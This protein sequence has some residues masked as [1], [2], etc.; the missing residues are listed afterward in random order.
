[1]SEPTPTAND[2][3]DEN[4]TAVAA[5][6]AAEDVSPPKV[7]EEEKIDEL[8]EVRLPIEEEE[9]EEKRNGEE[10]PEDKDEDDDKGDESDSEGGAQIAR[11]RRKRR[12][13]ELDEDDY[14]LLE[15]NQVTGFKRKEK[16]KRLQKK[17][18]AAV[19]EDDDDDD[20]EKEDQQKKEQEQEQEEKDT[21]KDEVA[22]ADEE[23]G[24]E[25]EQQQ[26]QDDAEEEKRRAA[27][28]E[29][30]FVDSDDEDSE[31]EMADFIVRDEGEERETDEERARRKAYNRAQRERGGARYDQV[32]EAA[33][34][35]GDISDLQKL[36]ANRK[37]PGDEGYLGGESLPEDVLEEESQSEYE[38]DDE[39]VDDF[40]VDDE[41]GGERPPREKKMRKVRKFKKRTAGVTPTKSWAEFAF[42]PSVIKAQMLTATDDEIRNADWP[43]RLS[44]ENVQVP[45]LNTPRDFAEEATWIYDRVMGVGSIRGIPTEAGELLLRGKMDYESDEVM[46]MRLYQLQNEWGGQLPDTERQNVLI[47]IEWFLKMVRTQGYELEYLATN[48]RDDLHPLLRGKPEEARPP[49]VGDQV[50]IQRKTRSFDVLQAVYDWDIAYVKLQNRK[51]KAIETLNKELEAHSNDQ[52]SV[53]TLMRLQK[54]IASSKYDENVQDVESK[55]QLLLKDGAA[56]LD[57]NSTGGSRRPRRRTAYDMHVSRD[58]LELFKIS[59]PAPEKVAMALDTT[60][61]WGEA[62]GVYDV[63]DDAMTEILPDASPEELAKHYLDQGYEDEEDVIKAL[64]EVSATELANDPGIRQWV[65]FHYRQY[66]QSTTKPT[67]LGNEQIDTFHPLAAVKRTLN[68]P[69]C[70]F[71]DIEFSM[72]AEGVRKGLLEFDAFLPEQEVERLVQNLSNAYC[73]ENV[74]EKAEQWNTIRRKVVEDAIKK[75]LV[76]QI[77]REATAQL[78]LE[79]KRS[80]AIAAFNGAWRMLNKKSWTPQLIGVKEEDVHSTLKHLEVRIISAVPASDQETPTTLVS[81]D[82]SG[83]LVDFLELTSFG[84]SG[85]GGSYGTQQEEQRKVA[86][87]ISNHR[88]HLVAV[89]ASGKNA[90][91]LKEE[92]DRVTGGFLEKDGFVKSIPE[93]VS[94]IE[95]E[96]INDSVASLYETASAPVKEMG[97][98]QATI[99]HAVAL[100]RFARDPAAVV[101]NLLQPSGGSHEAATISLCPF[102]DAALSREERV[103][104]IERALRCCINQ[105]GVDVNAAMS[106]QWIARSLEHVAGL[107]PRKLVPFLTAIRKVDGGALDNREE[108]LTELHAVEE[109]VYENAASA[110]NIT[111]GNVLDGSRIHP[112]HYDKAIA[113][114]SNALDIQIDESG[115]GRERAL[116]RCFDPREWPKLSVLMLE[117]YANYLSTPEGG[118]VNALEILRDIRMEMRKPFE[119]VRSEWTR[120]SSDEIF[121]AVTGETVHTLQAGKLITCT[122]KRIDARANCVIVQLDSGVTG[123]I[124]RQDVSDSPFDRLDDKVHVGQVITARVK[125]PETTAYGQQVKGIDLENLKVWLTCRG[126]H[127][128]EDESRRWEEHV[129]A[130]T[131]PYYSLDPLPGE[132]TIAAARASKPKK[133]PN[134]VKHEKSYIARTIDH[135]LFKNCS[136]VEA[137]AELAD[138]DVGDFVIRPSSKGVKNLSCTIKM[139]DDVYWHMDIREGK[140]PGTG[141]TANLRLGTPL[142]IDTS[143]E[144]YEDLDEAVARHIE[145]VAGFLRDAVMHR[146]FLGG[147]DH[148]VDEHLQECFRKN[149]NQRP[150]ALSVSD[151][152]HGYLCISYIMSASGNVH[153][154]YVEV[155]PIGYYYR[156]MEFPTVDRMLAHFK[157][158][159]NKPVDR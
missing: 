89:A 135:P 125:A 59:S 123:V 18:A 13:L 21:K 34:I 112:K 127:L 39:D 120:L 100:G 91:T 31:E 15:D 134:Q 25:K 4:G 32:R 75:K 118:G 30:R 64:I 83:Q 121:T 14:D 53:A 68:K 10:E 9:E 67:L 35:F 58:V 153:H 151:K 46:E 145:P 80:M 113:I 81:L 73:S 148:E 105:T 37:R 8:E 3:E 93:E 88:P 139:F 128:S 132:K 84:K 65:R 114:A 96:F 41:E 29:R 159:C 146:K 154:E 44:I 56:A 36:F 2:G 143:K 79:S 1:M 20:D 54:L 74:S 43:E 102:Q 136:H 60:F 104:C 49:L 62:E 157:V 87:F 140:K 129:L 137:T 26:Q 117:D 138:G 78:V 90:K 76:P 156:K 92:L 12:A 86:E 101:A 28:P 147:R 55:M 115:V 82:G 119:D 108:I 109:R 70:H 51:Q 107:G 110:I 85:R 155:R 141:G 152:H 126:S 27:A 124:E 48:M 150:Y 71:T 66:A 77:A 5:A 72:I 144:K 45:N 98:L 131:T 42:E 63:E 130:T 19:G 116:E 16:K 6:P 33:D 158:N 99:R 133:K 95:V 23:A 57:A 142:M 38:T 61:A 24:D 7:V 94:A 50:I 22:G 103:S 47:C 17:S 97:E 149:R 52:Q 111:D 11:R 122:V 40:I 106:H 69:L